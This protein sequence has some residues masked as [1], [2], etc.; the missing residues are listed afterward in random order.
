M[1]SHF[2]N[3]GGIKTHYLE[4]GQG[5]PIILLHGGGAGADAWGNW[6]G[7]ISLL[8]PHFR[9][10]AMDMVGFGKTEKPDPSTFVYSQNARVKHLADFIEAMDL[11]KASLVGNSMGGATSLGVCM[12]RPEL[13]DKLV[14]MGSAGL[15]AQIN[16]AI[17][18][19]LS[20]AP[21]REN[22]Q[23]L[24]R[25]LTHEGFSVDP[26]LIDYRLELTQQPGVMAAYGATMKWVAEQGG[27]FYPEEAI[28][29]VKHKTLVV[30]G[31]QDQVVPPELG[32]K[33]S[34]L[35]ESSW[36]YLIPHCGHWA[37]IEHPQEFCDIVTRFLAN[38]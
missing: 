2:V 30:N 19:I 31:K 38:A 23:K 5:K 28:R 26:G 6:Q 24:V 4:A 1:D 34:Q 8:A 37:M 9:V 36:L 3:A 14:L 17:R 16:E 13:V 32:W 33:F 35:L 20:Y 7:C 12:S 15:N 18:V 21:S 10:L 22:M 11:K 29:Q 25:V 27:L